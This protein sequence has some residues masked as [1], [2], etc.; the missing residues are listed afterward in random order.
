MASDDKFVMYSWTWWWGTFWSE[1]NGIA[2]LFTMLNSIRVLKEFS[3]SYWAI[4]MEG[5]FKYTF[6]F[7]LERLFVR[8]VNDVAL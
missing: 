4:L 8:K 6:D 1:Q 2:K 3:T 7:F 5:F